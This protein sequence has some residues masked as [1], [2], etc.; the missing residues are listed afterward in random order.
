MEFLNTRARAWVVVINNYQV[1]DLGLFGFLYENDEHCTYYVA[2]LEVG[3]NGTPHIQAYV[4]FSNAKTGRFMKKAFPTAHLEPARAREKLFANRYLYCMKFQDERKDPETGL[5]MIDPKGDYIEDGVRPNPGGAPTID[6]KTKVMDAIEEGMSVAELYKIFPT[7]MM[8]HHQKAEDFIK[9]KKIEEF[10]STFCPD[11]TVFYYVHLKN[12]Q[13]PLNEVKKFVNLKAYSYMIL[14]ELSYYVDR[15]PT[16]IVIYCP[17]NLICPEVQDWP[18]TKYI[19]ARNGFRHVRVICK[20]MIVCTYTDEKLQDCGYKKL[21]YQDILE[22]CPT[23][24][25]RILQHGVDQPTDQLTAEPI[26]E[27]GLTKDQIELLKH[28]ND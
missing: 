6:L 20:V 1:T 9:F 28:R 13:F 22:R 10:K 5:F 17:R 25:E 26:T 11:N 7:Y 2:G 19:D 12:K 4:H 18:E 23:T 8:Y 16:D 21:K 3:A 27:G 24:A 15:D 14:R